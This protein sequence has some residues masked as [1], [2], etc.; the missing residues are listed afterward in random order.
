MKELL[1]SLGYKLHSS[2]SCSGTYAERYKKGIYHVE[3]KP[4]RKVW[5]LK[6][7]GVF[8]TKGTAENLQ[9]KLQEY[10]VI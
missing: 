3:I 7:S 5:S 9:E 4:N 1:I 6:I 8:A 2:C 10:G